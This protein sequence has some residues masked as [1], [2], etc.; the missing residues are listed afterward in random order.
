MR[1]AKFNTNG[2]ALRGADWGPGEPL[3]KRAPTRDADG[4]CVSDFMMLIPKLRER[5]QG[6]VRGVM[7]SIQRVF[8]AYGERVLFADLNLKLNVLWVSVRPIPG[9]CLEMAA[10]IKTQVPEAVLVA[11][12]AEAMWAERSRSA[13][14]RRR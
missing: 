10:A 8:D 14:R 2:N 12:R 3:W 6:Y 13:K 4:H 1:L 5:P 7:N 11:S 9:I